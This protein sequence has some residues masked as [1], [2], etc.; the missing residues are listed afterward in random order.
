MGHL[1]IVH[2]FLPFFFFWVNV[3]VTSHILRLFNNG[4]VVTCI[5]KWMHGICKVQKVW[6]GKGRMK[7]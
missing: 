5:L 2:Y 4:S 7:S 3:A 1:S 6:K